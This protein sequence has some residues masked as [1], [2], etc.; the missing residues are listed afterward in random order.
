MRAV[1]KIGGSLVNQGAA[2]GLRWF[3]WCHKLASS[4]RVLVVVGG[5]LTVDALRTMAS[6]WPL[7]EVAFHWRALR[8]MDLNAGLVAE[9]YGLE[10]VDQLDWMDG[11]QG[12]AVWV[13]S[14]SLKEVPEL[15]PSWRTTSDTVAAWLSYRAKAAAAV[16][17][18][19]VDPP[20]GQ[21]M[22]LTRRNA[23]Y[24]QLHFDPEVN[25]WLDRVAIWWQGPT[26]LQ[27]EDPGALLR[28]DEEVAN[29][30]GSSR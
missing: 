11:D 1:V 28:G 12:L 14:E 9:Y 22:R 5:G 20:A 18:K 16:V 21:P 29:G 25:K 10:A 30:G 26:G 4:H 23:A 2:A 13:G 24:W 27:Q 6:R 7:G 15:D 3:T 19:S 17:F 8:L